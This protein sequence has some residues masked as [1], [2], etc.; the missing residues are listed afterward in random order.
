MGG[1]SKGA[2]GQVLVN[3]TRDVGRYAINLPINGK[4]CAD[5]G[6][7]IFD[8]GDNE[9][10]ALEMFSERGSEPWSASKRHWNK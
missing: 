3:S 4:Y 6:Y 2:I 1:C 5:K 9:L 8:E 7:N 10:C